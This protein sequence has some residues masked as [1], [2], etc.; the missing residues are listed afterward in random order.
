MN[1]RKPLLALGIVLSLIGCGGGDDS[2]TTAVASTC[3]SE[4]V[5]TVN[6]PTLLDPTP[7]GY[8]H[9]T[10][11]TESGVAY[12]AGQVAFSLEGAIVGDTLEEQLVLVEENL[13]LALSALDAGV[14]DILRMNV[15]I[16]NFQQN[17][18]LAVLEP[19]LFRMGSPVDAVLGVRSL[20]VDGLLVEVQ[21]T[22]AVKPAT[23]DRIRCGNSA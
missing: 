9:I 8:K 21:I 12:V 6:P 19:F 16:V 13:R 2:P 22:V 17:P 4:R 11:D 18:D 7:F 3:S 15:F 5:I 10:L 20:A 1:T 14:E 23:V